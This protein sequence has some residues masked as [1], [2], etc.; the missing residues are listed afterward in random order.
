MKPFLL[1]MIILAL[2]APRV[3]AQEKGLETATRGT[4]S[5]DDRL[6]LAVREAP[7]TTSEFS[8][9]KKLRARGPLVNIFKTRKIR[10]VPRRMFHF[11]NPFATV[12]AG[13]RLERAAD[14][15]PRA[16]TSTVG[17]H[18]GR[19]AF[20]DVTTHESTMSLVTV[21]R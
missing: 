4:T 21:G 16:W 14:V 10:D 1:V 8:V 20:P 15:N 17:L 19:S 18:P 12:E 11:I 2:A 3:I 13:E 9:G 7:F 6:S 5:P